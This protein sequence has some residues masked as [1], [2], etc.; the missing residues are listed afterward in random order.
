MNDA[1]GW[2]RM[3]SGASRTISGPISFGVHE[4]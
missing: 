1:G 2:P 3:A 4:Y